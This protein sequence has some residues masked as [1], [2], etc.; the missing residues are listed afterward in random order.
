M[1]K[2]ECKNCNHFFTK[3]CDNYKDV[4]NAECPECSSHWVELQYEK[5]KIFDPFPRHPY[6]DP[7]YPN[8]NID[9]WPPA[10]YWIHSPIRY[11][12]NEHTGSVSLW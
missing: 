2:F 1:A 6:D 11:S 10:R 4:E 9:T 12:I 8:P 5:K 3:F 7:I